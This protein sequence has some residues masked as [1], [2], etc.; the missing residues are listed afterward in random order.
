[1]SFRQYVVLLTDKR[2]VEM[3]A[4]PKKYWDGSEH[5][6]NFYDEVPRIGSG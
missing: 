4:V 1:M 2:R 5:T 3:F 6:V